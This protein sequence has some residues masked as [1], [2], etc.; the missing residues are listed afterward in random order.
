MLTHIVLFKLKERTA[1]NRMATRDR[2]AQIEGRIPQLRSLQV[3]INEL[4]T[5]F[6]YDLVMVAILD[7]LDDLHSFQTHPVHQ[8]L[9]RD[10][11]PRYEEFHSV[12][13]ES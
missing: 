9:L 10:V 8:E 5:P 7:S 12:D 6:S 11:M 4:E 1:E 2:I 13:F 3:G